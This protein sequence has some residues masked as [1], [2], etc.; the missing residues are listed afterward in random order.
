D[1]ELLAVPR[2]P[3]KLAVVPLPADRG[4]L[5]R[6]ADNR[7]AAPVSDQPPVFGESTRPAEVRHQERR[8]ARRASE[9]DGPPP[10]EI[11]LAGDREHAADL[12]PVLIDKLTDDRVSAPEDVE[13][14]LVLGVEGHVMLHRGARVAR[15]RDD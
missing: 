7:R 8:V 9:R 1:D 14:D 10:G 12:R 6:G 11:A 5:D 4:D 3:R 13:V 15:D 2:G